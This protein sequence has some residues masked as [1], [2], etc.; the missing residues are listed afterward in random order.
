MPREDRT[1]D[2]ARKEWEKRKL[3]PALKRGACSVGADAVVILASKSQTSETRTGYY[4]D[5]IAIVYG[6]RRPAEI[7]GGKPASRYKIQ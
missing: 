3:A 6:K 2:A 4:I 1:L 5:A 7:E